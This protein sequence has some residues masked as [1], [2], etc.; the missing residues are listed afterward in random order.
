M[1]LPPI[2]AD[3]NDVYFLHLNTT[4]SLNDIGKCAN[5]AQCTT[6]TVVLPSINPSAMTVFGNNLYYV[7]FYAVPLGGGPVFSC[8][9]AG[10]TQGTA[11]ATLPNDTVVDIT[12]DSSGV[13]FTGASTVYMCPYTGCGAAGPKPIAT[14]QASPTTIHT[15]ADFVYWLNTGGADAGASGESIVRVAK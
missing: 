10:C 14:G 12:S 6:P 5:T 9:T 4:T 11:F 8:A 2:A 3:A 15:D 13:Y 7:T 1:G